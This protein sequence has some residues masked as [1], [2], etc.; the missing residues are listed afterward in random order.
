MTDPSQ[1]QSEKSPVQGSEMSGKSPYASEKENNWF[2]DPSWASREAAP[3][4]AAASFATNGYAPPGGLPDGPSAP[5]QGPGGGAPPPPP[6]Y[7]G[8]PGGSFAPPP[9]AS[10]NYYRQ[11]APGYIPPS[12]PPAVRPNQPGE[13]PA[14]ASLIVG[15]IALLLSF[16]PLLGTATALGGLIP[17]I[18]ARVKGHRAGTSLAGI[19]LSALA[20]GISLAVIAAVI[21]LIFIRRD[22]NNSTEFFY[23]YDL[24]R[25]M[26]TAWLSLRMLP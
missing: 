15:I 19:L 2:S 22:Y 12:Y 26:G 25:S 18:I 4:S 14:L 8:Q 11:Q 6:S 5:P 21:G 20:L 3:P 17:G 9:A 16:V 13:G 23:N 1:N 24:Y 7:G 10:Y